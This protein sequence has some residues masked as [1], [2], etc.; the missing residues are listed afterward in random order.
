MIAK[1]KKKK[2]IAFLQATRAIRNM[3]L[4]MLKLKPQTLTMETIVLLH[5]M[6]K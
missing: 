5:T 2:K 4:Q 3:Y 6:V 1:R